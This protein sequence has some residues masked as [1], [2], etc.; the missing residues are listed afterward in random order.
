MESIQL[1]P[2]DPL[3]CVL[4]SPRFSPH[5][6]W[7]YRD[8]CA[9]WE[10][11]APA[12]PL[13]LL[14]VAALLP[15]HWRFTVLDL[16]VADFDEKLWASADIVAVGGM[17]VQ[18]F[19]MLEV[20]QR[21]RAENKFVMVGGPDPSSQ[22]EVY[23]GASALFVGEVE[24]SLPAWYDGWCNG[25]SP[26]GVFRELDG[27]PD[28]TK[29]PPPRFDLLT[30]SFYATISLQYS[31][32]CPFSCEFC[33]IIELYGRVPR[34]KT[35]EQITQ[36]LT[37]IK[38]LGYTGIIDIV[39]DN[40]IGNKRNVK[41]HLLPA[42][43]EWNKKNKYPF[44]YVTEA[45]MNLGD[46]DALLQAMATA[47]FRMVFMGIETP[48]KELLLK[49]QKSQNTVGP[50]ATRVRNIF[51]HGIGVN[52]GFILGFDG[53]EANVADAMIDLIEEVPIV[54]AMI[55]L[56]V[57]LPNTQLSRRLAKEGRLLKS[58]TDEGKFAIKLVSAQDVNPVM[59]TLNF[60]TDRPRA[61]IL[62]DYVRVLE[63]LYEPMAYCRRIWR[64]VS[65]MNIRRKHR[66]NLKMFLR[67]IRA[68]IRLVTLMVRD[69]TT[70]KPFLW[71]LRRSG[72]K[73][74]LYLEQTMV[75]IGMYVH[76]RKIAYQV[77]GFV[78]MHS[79]EAQARQAKEM[80]EGLQAKDAADAMYAMAKAQSLESVSC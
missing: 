18:Q 32:G 65:Q 44:T 27:K 13:G 35:P 21:A 26:V 5:T 73:G 59:G 50:I 38:N 15:Q 57:A 74:F 39:D 30:T 40:F 70:R 25:A 47:E 63:T 16:N 71:L 75:F 23:M 80:A 45:S 72:R 12:P 11:K 53:E 48:S 3:H 66:P 33:D 77:R 58:Q 79:S 10:T 68:F 51:R 2:R 49:T 76:L 61:D 43:I 46:D 67:S 36:E 20:I 41:R 9:I 42:L 54:M 52:A 78:E 60:A 1:N 22:P 24:R 69:E 31:R 17:L 7:N 56:L 62:N 6:F 19:G 64:M 4:I 28:V 37:M 29:I 34:T 55:G 8:T 14:T